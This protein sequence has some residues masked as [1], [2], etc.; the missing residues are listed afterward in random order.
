MKVLSIAACLAIGLSVVTA[1]P[2]LGSSIFVKRDVCPVDVDSCS[3]ESIDVNTCC[4]PKNG[5]VKLSQQWHT[6]VGPAD[7]FTIHGKRKIT[8]FHKPPW[9][10]FEHTHRRY[11]TP[12]PQKI[13]D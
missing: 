12:L 3:P 8:I 5:F 4:L 9:D 1:H 11:T 10:C 6:K 7:A 13:M 2:I